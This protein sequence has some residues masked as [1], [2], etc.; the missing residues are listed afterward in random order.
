MTDYFKEILPK[1]E[2]DTQEAATNKGTSIEIKIFIFPGVLANSEEMM[3]LAKAIQGNYAESGKKA[4]IY[5]YNEELT[6]SR[7]TPSFNSLEH[8]QAIA[9]AMKKICK[10]SPS[11]A[12]TSIG[13]SYGAQ[14]A[15]GASQILTA[16][17]KETIVEVI[18]APSP[19]TAKKYH[20]AYS[21]SFKQDLINIIHYAAKIAFAEPTHHNSLTLEDRS[22]ANL[23]EA[24]MLEALIDKL[25]SVIASKYAA[26]PD[27]SV[28]ETDSFNFRVRIAK[29]NLANL[30]LEEKTPPTILLPNIDV[31]YTGETVEKYAAHVKSTAPFTGGWDAYCKKCEVLSAPLEMSHMGIISE[32]SVAQLANL[33]VTKL[34]SYQALNPNTIYSRQLYD[35]IA[36]GLSDPNIDD[37]IK[38]ELK[39]TMERISKKVKNHSNGVAD[40]FKFML[41][42]AQDAAA[43][44][45]KLRKSATTVITPAMLGSK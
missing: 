5:I 1:A 26:E 12:Y 20:D 45:V 9:E 17:G 37:E 43:N 36:P 11:Q 8:H 7:A 31:I 6:P 41:F 42:G 24:Y 29:R 4:T 34:T 21:K 16:E 15:V 28:D 14:L 3:S 22:V 35:T 10:E 30:F 23:F 2:Y 44:P 32:K 18:D 13:F 39:Q 19:D 25:A 27:T 40:V 33:I 38:A